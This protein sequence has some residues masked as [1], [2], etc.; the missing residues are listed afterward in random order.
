VPGKSD[1]ADRRAVAAVRDAARSALD[2][3]PSHLLVDAGFALLRMLEA[4]VRIS[5]KVLA[6]RPGREARDGE[7]EPPPRRVSR[8]APPSALSVRPAPSQE[9]AFSAGAVLVSHP[10]MRRD[11]VLL[12]QADGPAGYAFGVVTNQPTGAPLGGG[13]LAGP[14]SSVKQAARWT[15]G[16][17]QLRD[18][19]HQHRRVREAELELFSE[20]TVFYGGPDGGWNVTM[21]H[22]HGGVAGCVRVRDG[23]YY[24]GDLA[25]AAAMVRE[26]EAAAADFC[27]YRGRIDWQPGQLAGECEMGEWVAGGWDVNPR[28]SGGGDDSFHGLPSHSGGDAEGGGGEARSWPPPGLMPRLARYAATASDLQLSDG[29][30]GGGGGGGRLRSYKVGAWAHVVSALARGAEEAAGGE[31]PHPLHDWLR[32][33]PVEAEEAAE[34]HRGGGR[35]A[36]GT[37]Q[38]PAWRTRE[39]WEAAEK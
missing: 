7:L 19:M 35:N 22:P 13:P 17:R 30:L 11:V 26:G 2:V 3:A 34:L 10:L 16:G 1:G 31:A 15:T 18:E 24:G 9:E 21:L 5:E 6:P 33:H 4:P 20:S 38:P 29:V 39:D 27:F 37:L 14:A 8:P 32:L 36:E 12:L 23:L 25:S 28:G